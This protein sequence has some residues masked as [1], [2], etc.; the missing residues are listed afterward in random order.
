[1]CLAI[2]SKVLEIKGARGKVEF[3]GVIKEV[4]FTLLEGVRVGDFVLI[5]AGYAMEKVNEEEA[6]ETLA[7]M[8]QICD[9]EIDERVA[10]AK[11]E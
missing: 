11:G 8:K 9:L 3:G 1:M 6:Y 10:H 2:P 5:H 4:S 7:L